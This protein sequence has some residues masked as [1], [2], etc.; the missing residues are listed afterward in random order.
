MLPTDYKTT[1]EVSALTGQAPRT[2]Q[3]H[4]RRYGLGVKFL[5]TLLFTEE[6]IEHLREIRARGQQRKLVEPKP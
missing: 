6:D 4:A 1:R 3:I 5:N 2:I